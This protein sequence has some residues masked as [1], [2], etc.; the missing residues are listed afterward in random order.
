MISLRAVTSAGLASCLAMLL[1]SCSTAVPANV[2]A[3]V[4]GRPI[5][6]TEIDSNYKSQFP[7]QGEG[8]NEDQVQLRRIEILGSLIDNEIM[9]QR[10]EKA[11]LVAPDS[12]VTQRL[13][14]MKTP[15][16]VEDFDKQLKAWGITLEQLKEHIRKDESVK[17]LFN[18]EISSKIAISDKDVS[19]FYNANRPSFNLPE[20]QVH[21][22]QILVTPRADPSVRNLKN[23]KAKTEAEARQKIQFLETRLKQGDEFATLAE[24]YSED[25]QSAPNGGDMGFI[26][27]SSLDK[28]SP[29]LKKMVLSMRPGTVSQI[30]PSQDGYRILKVISREPAGQRELNDPRVQ[31]TIRET[32]QSRRDQLL[33]SAYYGIARNEAKV[34]DYMAVR[35]FSDE[36]KK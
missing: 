33:K 31:Q 20:P 32:L 19:D 18:K 9:F 4:N 30:I 1:T 14:E 34:M 23:D 36:T 25:T 27:E 2:A 28:S 17:L 21:M 16:T 29:E 6:Y 5:Y 7:A 11:S 8:E 3:T 15:Y 12:T 10:A 35:I 26:P 22:A 24:N 13:T